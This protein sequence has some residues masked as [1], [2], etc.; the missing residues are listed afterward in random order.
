MKSTL[1]R[2]LIIMLGMVMSLSL[3]SCGDDDDNNE[4]ENPKTVAYYDANYGIDLKD[5]WF[6][7][8]DV[9][10]SYVN[11]A[12][13]VKTETI[14]SNKVLSARIAANKAPDAISFKIHVTRKAS[15]SE[16]DPTKPIDFKGQ[17]TFNVQAYLTDGTKGT[18]YGY[19]F[20]ENTNG[21]IIGGAD[22]EK[23]L[24]KY[25]NKDIFDRSFDLKK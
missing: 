23:F 18:S 5:A 15:V 7:F 9:T 12:G 17:A 3:V 2:T 4:P 25:N 14:G 19:L 6:E 11:E 16:V 10:V 22:L 8:F 20:P 1:F 24:E 21:T 13:E